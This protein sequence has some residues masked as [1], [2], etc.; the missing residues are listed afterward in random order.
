M[1]VESSA[2]NQMIPREQEV[3]TTST[4]EEQIAYPQITEAQAAL[5]QAAKARNANTASISNEK[6][7][8]PKITEAQAKLIQAAEERGAVAAK[9]E[10]KKVSKTKE[11]KSEVVKTYHEKQKELAEIASYVSASHRNE[12]NEIVRPG[13]LELIFAKF[14]MMTHP[15]LKLKEIMNG[16]RLPPNP[17]KPEN[18][19]YRKYKETL[20]ANKY[21]EKKTEYFPEAAATTTKQTSAVAA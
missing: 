20:N 17:N 2:V 8:A 13:R 21:C 12:E 5:I 15:V 19:L 18:V 1:A 11:S 10:T 14:F 4:G 6:P 7:A 3:V 9:P 16:G